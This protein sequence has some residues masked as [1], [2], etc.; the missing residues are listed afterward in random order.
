MET[1]ESL[2]KVLEQEGWRNLS[3]TPKRIIAFQKRVDGDVDVVVEIRREST[4]FLVYSS[5]EHRTSGPTE[6]LEGSAVLLSDAF[7]L[8]ASCCRY[9][10]AP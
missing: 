4:S 6:T 2:I 9:W 1:T 7:Q 3:E 8:V 10:D 5:A